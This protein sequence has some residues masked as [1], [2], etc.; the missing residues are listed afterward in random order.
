HSELPDAEL[1][2]GRDVQVRAVLAAPDRPLWLFTLD[3]PP[4]ARLA[5]EAPAYDH[6]L[7]ITG[8]A[9]NAAGREIGAG[10]ALLVEHGARVEAAA[11][12]SGAA[13][14]HFRPAPGAPAAERA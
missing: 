13:A 1:R 4:G 2:A 9:L 5:W 11:G 6:A 10:G 7:Y 12:A 8:G 3:L 14:L